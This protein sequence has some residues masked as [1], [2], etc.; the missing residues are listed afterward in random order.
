MFKHFLLFVIS[1]LLTSCSILN[2]FTQKYDGKKFTYQLID[3]NGNIVK[4]RNNILLAKDI[5]NIKIELSGISNTKISIDRNNIDLLTNLFDEELITLVNRL[6]VSNLEISFRDVYGNLIATGDQIL[7]QDN[8]ISIYK[9]DEYYAFLNLSSYGVSFY[10]NELVSTIG[11]DNNVVI[12][13]GFLE[14]DN[15]FEYEEVKSI[16]YQYG[17]EKLNTLQKM[18]YNYYKCKVLTNSIITND[19]VNS[20]GM[21]GLG[22]NKIS[23]MNGLNFAEANNIGNLILLDDVDFTLKLLEE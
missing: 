16:V 3:D 10:D 12:W 8:L 14:Q 22:T 20:G 15:F 7:E 11:I 1:L 13:L 21:S 9:Y 2:S 18:T 4:N 17:F 6:M 19:F 23:I 5:M